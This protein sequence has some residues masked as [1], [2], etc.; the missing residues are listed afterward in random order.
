MKRKSNLYQNICEFKNIESAFIEVCKNTKNKR[1]VENLKEYKNIYISRIYKILSQKRYIVGPYTKF[2][3]YEP[4]KRQI[5]SQNMQDKIINHLVARFIL[6]PALL[7]CLLD[8]NVASRKNM[9][10]SKGISLALHF[11]NICNIKYQTYYILKCDIKKFFASI[12]H[13][14][15]KEKLKRRIKDKDALKIVFDIIDSN[16]KGL[17]IGSMTNQ[18]LAIFYLN[19][20]DHFIKEE[21]KIKYYV[22]YQDDFLLFHKSKEYLNF[23]M[24]K[25]SEFLYSEDLTLNSKTRIFKN[26]N[27][28]MFL[29]RNIKGNYCRYRNV[30]RKLKSKLHQYKIG[31]IKLNSFISSYICYKGL[32]KRE[33]K[34]KNAEQKRTLITLLLFITF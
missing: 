15:L 29:G 7:P 6:Y 16:D 31:N 11:R 25:I 17:Y 20:M 21:L 19:D 30:K 24:N 12:N 26:N 9:G 10:T 22:R 23:C 14:I 27:N 5:V 32:C 8:V 1:R 28:F 13:N 3:I 33:F 4:K 2:I 18:I 34:L